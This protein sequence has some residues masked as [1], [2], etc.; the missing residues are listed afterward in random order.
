[1][2]IA[3]ANLRNRLAASKKAA[4]YQARTMIDVPANDVVDFLKLHDLLVK[5]LKRLVFLFPGDIPD[6]D[7]LEACEELRPLL[8]Q[9][10]REANDTLK[11]T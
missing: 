5:R 9:A 2:T 10:V 7:Y 3:I 11:G 4:T 8:T 6:E 1:M